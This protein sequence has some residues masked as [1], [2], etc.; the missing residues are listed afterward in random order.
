VGRMGAK[1]RFGGKAIYDTVRPTK[2]Q[3]SPTSNNTSL[4]ARRQKKSVAKSVDGENCCV[5]LR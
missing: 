1:G 3:L 5:A 2:F 4:M